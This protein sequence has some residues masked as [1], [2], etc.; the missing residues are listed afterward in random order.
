MQVLA[1]GTLSPTVGT[2]STVFN[3]IGTGSN[4]YVVVIDLSNL[5][6]TDIV[7]IEIKTRV[8]G[9]GSVNIVSTGSYR[10]KLIEPILLSPPIPSDQGIQ[11][12]I[13]QTEGTAKNIDWKVL[14]V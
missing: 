8:L 11:V 12:D 13:T 7:V 4:I 3:D 1:S 5:D 10:G 6:Y 14:A 2:T 9:T